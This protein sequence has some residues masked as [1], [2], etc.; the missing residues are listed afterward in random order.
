[1]WP[2]GTRQKGLL[3]FQTNEQSEKCSGQNKND[4]VGGVKTKVDF[5]RLF[6]ICIYDRVMPPRK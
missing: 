5:R 4:P 2:Q 6:M 1:M 3:L